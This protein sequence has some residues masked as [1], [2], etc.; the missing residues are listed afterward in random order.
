MFVNKNDKNKTSN[1]R[2][3]REYAVS[4]LV[5]VVVA[6]IFHTYVFA[7]ANVDGPSM[8]PTLHTNDALFIEKIS[9]ELSDIKRGEIVIFK[10][11]ETNGSYYV[12]R[13]IGIAGDKIEIKDGHV[14]LNGQL[15][16]E[17]YLAPN[18][19]TEPLTSQSVYIVPKGDVFVLGDNRTNSTD[20]RIL[21]PIKITD[22]KGHAIARL[23]PFNKIRIF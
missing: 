14:F 21:G 20:S 1:S 7:R 22:V 23:F 4:I 2:K 6:I 3:V 16:K 9:T 18:T 13:V 11:K 19:M 17:D 12:K 5:A 15:L 10:N 8:Q